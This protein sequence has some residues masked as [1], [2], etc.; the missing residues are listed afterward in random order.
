MRFWITLL[1]IRVRLLNVTFFESCV[2]SDKL[3][4]DFRVCRIISSRVE[5]S[6]EPNIGQAFVSYRKF[7]VQSFGFVRNL[8][9]LYQF[10][11]LYHLKYVRNSHFP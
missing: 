1:I 11:K 2:L 4:K 10:L 9:K 3:I 6:R 8:V 5:V 7:A